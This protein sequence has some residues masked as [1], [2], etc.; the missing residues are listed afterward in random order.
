MFVGRSD[1][2]S[3]VCRVTNLAVCTCR[4]V[5]LAVRPSNIIF[6]GFLTYVNCYRAVVTECPC[7]PPLFVYFH[8]FMA[9]SL[10]GGVVF[11]TSAKKSHLS[12]GE[13]TRAGLPADMRARPCLTGD[14]TGKLLDGTIQPAGC[15]LCLVCACVHTC[16]VY[17]VCCRFP[18]RALKSDK[19]LQ[20]QRSLVALQSKVK[21]KLPEHAPLML[22]ENSSKM[23][24]KVVW[25]GSMVAWTEN[26][27]RSPC[28]ALR[29]R[30]T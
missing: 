24:H 1:N 8:D 27:R 2:L 7:V 11:A 30:G 3:V 21:A 20:W 28:Q 12:L 22:G 5:G 4:F 18:S 10:S 14:A 25:V 9:F 26:S 17:F 13:K 29:S 6:L 19:P 15:L 23:V 16:N